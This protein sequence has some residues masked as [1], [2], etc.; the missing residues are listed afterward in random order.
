MPIQVKYFGSTEFPPFEKMVNNME[1]FKKLPFNKTAIRDSEI[2]VG[3]T[4]RHNSLAGLGWEM[5]GHIGRPH[6]LASFSQGGSPTFIEPPAGG[7][8]LAHDGEGNFF[9][10]RDGRW[11][12]APPPIPPPPDDDQP[13]ARKGN[14]WVPIKDDAMAPIPPPRSF[15]RVGVHGDLDADCTIFITRY[16]YKYSRLPGYRW[17]T[18]RFRVWANVTSDHGETFGTEFRYAGA[19]WRA[20]HRRVDDEL[21]IDRMEIT[22]PYTI[23]YQGGCSRPKGFLPDEVT[24]SDLEHEKLQAIAEEPAV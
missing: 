21:V 13:Y 14:E 2:D 4:K 1:E 19:T 15:P 12:P 17:G 7:G 20:L 5:S 22:Y 24:E 8:F 23:F 10:F 6:A 18:I 9:S 3:V 16:T 11:E